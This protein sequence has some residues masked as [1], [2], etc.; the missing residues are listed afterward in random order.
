MNLGEN[1]SCGNLNPKTI[2]SAE[3]KVESITVDKI[4]LNGADLSQTLGV[5]LGHAMT[6]D[7]N[8][9]S[10]IPTHVNIDWG[11]NI[12]WDWSN[13]CSCGCRAWTI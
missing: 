5:L 1:I 9:V 13:I 2:G 11:S 12:D 7:W 3:R 6:A 4:I 8:A 10:N